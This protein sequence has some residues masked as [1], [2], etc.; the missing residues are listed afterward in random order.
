MSP[1]KKQILALLIFLLVYAACAFAS[2]TFFYDQLTAGV[3]P[4]QTGP[5][6]PH[7]VLGLANV[8][9]I[10]VVYGLVGLAGIWFSLKLSLPAVYRPGAGW[11]AWV[12]QPM[13]IGLLL[14]MVLVLY[15]HFLAGGVQGRGFPHPAF[16]FSILASLSAAIGEE[17]LFRFFVFGLW[18]FI[19]NLVLRRW[20]KLNIS[21]AVPLWIANG[22]AALL[23][24]AS[25]LA[26]LGQSGI[27]TNFTPAVLA[28]IFLLNGL[29]GLVAGE[30]RMMNGL[31]AAIGIH[32]WADIV[33]HVLYP[34]F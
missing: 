28:E 22:I 8:A 6:V 10:L 34:F 14:G 13:W 12:V 33:W 20:L 31:V 21:L 9:I 7:W 30:R 32:F 15:D 26:G 17:I 16:P 23:F 18:A 19:L 24:A 25:H 1:N 29:V 2:F 5:N 4:A 11:S 27:I 3:S